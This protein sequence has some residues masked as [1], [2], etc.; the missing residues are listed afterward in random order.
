MET[1][2]ERKGLPRTYWRTQPELNWSLLSRS[3]K[4]QVCRDGYV[5]ATGRIDMLAL[6]GSMAWIRKEPGNERALF[7]HS[8]G[9]TIY[10]MPVEQTR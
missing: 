1:G 10:R 2:S 9:V 5:V 8:D 3:D 4:V 6:D 7:L